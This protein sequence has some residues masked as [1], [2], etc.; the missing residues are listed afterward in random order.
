MREKDE[1]PGYEAKNHSAAFLKKAA[2]LASKK[3]KRSKGRT[4]GR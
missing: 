2:R 1:T 3:S 4:K